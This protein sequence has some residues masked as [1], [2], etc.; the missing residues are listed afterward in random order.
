MIYL[1]QIGGTI[2]FGTAEREHSLSIKSGK[3]FKEADVD[4]AASDLLTAYP[5]D[6]TTIKRYAARLKRML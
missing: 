2:R 5:D 1:R 4:A 3:H 6:S